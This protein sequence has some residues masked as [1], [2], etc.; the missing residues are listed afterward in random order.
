[1]LFG[2]YQIFIYIALFVIVYNLSK[3]VTQSRA[4]RNCLLL[5]GNLF[6]LLTLVKEHTLIVLAILS[7]LVFLAGKLLQ[8]RNSK[9]LLGSTIS[10]VLI[11]FSIRNYPYLQDSISNS[12]LEFIKAPILSVQKLGLSY[13]LFRFLHFLIE[14]YRKNISK[15][16][17]FTFLNY[18]FF[19]PSIIAGPIDTY[20]NFSYW[21]RNQKLEYHR[22]LFLAG[23]TRIFIGAVK[24]LG[25]VPFIIHYAT[26]YTTLTADF[27]PVAAVFLSLLAY[28]AY[29]YLDFSGY[30]D[31][32]IGLAFLIIRTFL[33][34]FLSFGNAGT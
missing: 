14:S 11:L 28:S 15:S 21:L 2:N 30:S 34:A 27:Y 8:L 7:L 26:D 9:W 29:I 18:V 24:T 6:I 19:F 3:L 25:I 5:A 23:I 31:I 12:Y 33:K 22:S 20:S 32:A 10:F 13:I 16:N 17:F 4:V 1:M